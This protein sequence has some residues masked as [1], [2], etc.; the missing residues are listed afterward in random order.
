M[1]VHGDWREILREAAQRMG[2]AGVE[3]PAR[4]AR[5]LLAHA[6]GV[7]PVA[8]ILRETER[9]DDAALSAF[10]AL[11]QRRLRHEPVS[12]IRGW[13]EFY[14]RRF[15]VT[16]DVLDPRPETE[17]LVEHGIARLPRGGR[18]LDLG[19]GSGCILLSVLAE[20]P[21]ATGVGVDIS[22]A[23]LAVAERNAAAIGVG[24][25]VELVEG[26]WASDMAGVFDLV[27][28]NPPYIP[29]ADM[30]SLAP[31]VLDHDPHLALTPGPDGL[32]AYRAIVS[33]HAGRVRPGGWIGLE[34]GIGQSGPVLA[35]MA[36]AG[37]EDR[38]AF[39]DLAG[40]SRA[41]FGRR[42]QKGP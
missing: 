7:E 41:A 10:E 4:D 23:A 34:C 6:L 11:V 37:L 31:D 20:R 5:L 18:V 14:G 26:N 27:L 29:A 17:L 24:A 42:P 12:R 40:L 25:R 30:A 36:D 28:S 33:V 16:P 35:L 22:P 8:V 39:A 15:I 21:D 13:R 38:T 19:V 32:A 1:S 3:S 9:V 2:A